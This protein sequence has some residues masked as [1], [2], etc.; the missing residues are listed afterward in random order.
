MREFARNGVLTG[1][2]EGTIAALIH[3]GICFEDGLAAKLAPIC[4]KHARWLGKSSTKR[5]APA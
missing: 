3:N 2:P 5:A 1:T 4:E